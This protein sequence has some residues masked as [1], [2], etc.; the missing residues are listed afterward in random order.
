MTPCAP[1]S[2]HLTL[3]SEPELYFLLFL[4]FFFLNFPTGSMII[5]LP[6][7]LG[8]NSSS[9]PRTG[10]PAPPQRALPPAPT[11]KCWWAKPMSTRSVWSCS[12]AACPVARLMLGQQNVAKPG[13]SRM[14]KVTPAQQVKC[15]LPHAVLASPHSSISFYTFFPSQV[16][17][18]ELFE[19]QKS[20]R[21]QSLF[22]WFEYVHTL[23]NF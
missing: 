10:S 18:G 16:L 7:C 21:N 22:S 1:Q 20:A 3:I 19:L 23:I 17:Q 13:A 12:G 9:Q 6:C 14:W 8:S 5:C 4:F 15:A 11:W 2:Y